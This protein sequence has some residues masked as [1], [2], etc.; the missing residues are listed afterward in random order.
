[1][2]VV[3]VMEKAQGRKSELKIHVHFMIS[4]GRRYLDTHTVKITDSN[5]PFKAIKN[6]L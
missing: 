2:A 4:I 1:M 3:V 6:G 5:L